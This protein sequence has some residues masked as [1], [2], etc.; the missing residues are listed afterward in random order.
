MQ[1]SAPIYTILQNS[2]L[3]QCAVMFDRTKI[4]NDTTRFQDLIPNH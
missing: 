1:F 2:G 4:I 3:E